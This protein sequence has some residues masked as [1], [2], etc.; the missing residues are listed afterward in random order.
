MRSAV[1]KREYA[2]RPRFDGAIVSVVILALA[3]CVVQVSKAQVSDKSSG[4][5]L[6]LPGWH[7]IPNTTLASACPKDDSLH[8]TSGC[9]AVIRA[10]G[11]AAADTKRNRLLIWGGGHNDYYG[12]EVYA[13][14]LAS[15]RMTLLVPPTPQPQACVEVQRDGKPSSRH[16][17]FNLTYIPTTDKLF[18]FGGALACETGTASYATWTLDL[19]T[20]EW[21]MLDQPEGKTRPNGQPGLS[22]VVYDPGTKLVFIE[23]LNNL[24]KYDPAANKYSVLNSV[25][26]VDYHQSGVI[27]T[28][29]KLLLLVGGGQFWAISIAPGSNYSLQNWTARVRGCEMLMNQAYPGLAFD[30]ERGVV[31]GWAGGDSVYIFDAKAKSCKAQLFPNGPGEQQANGTNGRFAY[32]PALHKFALVNDW[33][34]DAVLLRLELGEP[35]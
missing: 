6:N 3:L 30:T 25:H 26:G 32:F 35:H 4:E 31:V 24:Y 15:Q 16:T 5:N 18:S 13:L 20:L 2:R 8:G 17:Y 11:G 1:R 19:E 23:D 14:D 34:Q 28:A 33:Q 21:K 29:L 12:N 9:A 10:W 27:D 7:T 22:V